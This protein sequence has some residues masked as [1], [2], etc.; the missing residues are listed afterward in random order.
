MKKLFAILMLAVALVLTA[1][2]GN[3]AP[4]ETTKDEGRNLFSTKDEGIFRV[5]MECNYAPYNWTQ[6]DDSNGGVAIA[7]ESTFA[8]GYDVAFAKRIADGLGMKLEIVKM[9]WDGLEPALRSGKIDAVIAGMSPTAER[10]ENADF[11]EAYYN[12]NLVMI[13][14]AEGVYAKAHGLEDFKGAKITGQLNT[15]HYGV[16]DQIEGVDKQPAIADFSTMRAAL[17][18]GLIDGYVSEKPE[19]ISAKNANQA[20]SFIEFEEGKGFNLPAEDTQIAVALRKGSKLTSK[21]NEIIQKV[22]LEERDEMM[23]EAIKNQPSL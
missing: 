12:T 17:Q 11:S 10:K 19:G 3:N 2:G 15:V 14:N 20:F 21:I 8:G 5:G 13:V 1:C 9:E 6:L 18:S 16:I 23:L 22:S 4:V 7:G